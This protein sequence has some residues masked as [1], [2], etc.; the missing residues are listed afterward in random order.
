M[1]IRAITLLITLAA[2]T[3]ALGCLSS[4]CTSRLPQPEDATRKPANV[5]ITAS[6]GSSI[7]SASFCGIY[8]GVSMLSHSAG[9]LTCARDNGNR[10]EIYRIVDG[11]CD[12]SEWVQGE[13]KCFTYSKKSSALY[14]AISQNARHYAYEL[15]IVRWK[16]RKLLDEASSIIKVSAGLDDSTWWLTEESLIYRVEEGGVRS[17]IQA[18]IRTSAI[19]ASTTDAD[20][21]VYATQDG[22]V[23]VINREGARVLFDTESPVGECYTFGGGNVLLMPYDGD[24]V[25]RKKVS[26]WTRAGE[27][28]ASIPVWSLVHHIDDKVVL[29]TGVQEITVCDYDGSVLARHDLPRA[30][31]SA[32]TPVDGES[33]RW[34]VG[35]ADGRV[36][37]VDETGRASDQKHGNRCFLPFAVWWTALSPTGDMFIIDAGVGLLYR[38]GIWLQVELDYP[39][40]SGIYLDGHTVIVTDGE[41]GIWLVK[42]TNKEVTCRRLAIE[43]PS[44][45]VWLMQVRG[46]GSAAFFVV[47]LSQGTLHIYGVEN[48]DRI[49]HIEEIE[50]S[51][52]LVT[53][54]VSE[55]AAICDK[56]A[57]IIP[58]IDCVVVIEAPDVKTATVYFIP[59]ESEATSYAVDS[60]K[61]VLYSLSGGQILMQG[62][63]GNSTY[64]RI[65]VPVAETTGLLCG[66]RGKLYANTSEGKV[67]ELTTQGWQNVKLPR[68]LVFASTIQGESLLQILSG[69]PECVTIK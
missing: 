23:G 28:L 13:L 68:Q 46:G 32:I 63:G 24:S 25:S 4:G 56:G 58:C 62:W 8:H 3:V 39:I 49:Q 45:K 38:D 22:E 19:R 53:E 20:Q 54:V 43:R 9:T 10:F 7:N 33:G 51:R 35:F 36:R 59:R 30:N 64:K 17:S 52:I 40:T 12:Q 6:D 16:L 21:L 41:S 44:E 57:L 48:L 29:Q 50:K 61:R 66:S 27:K 18:P 55:G 47:I 42:H 2:F 15:D 67:Y 69:P 5:P 60:R 31:L 1:A 14:F 37:I 11:R 26:I 34:Y 65:A